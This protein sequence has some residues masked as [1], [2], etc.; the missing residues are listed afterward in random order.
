MP[1]VRELEL[2]LRILDRKELAS[3]VLEFMFMQLYGLQVYRAMPAGCNS[4]Q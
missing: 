1:C 4:A 3:L 2:E